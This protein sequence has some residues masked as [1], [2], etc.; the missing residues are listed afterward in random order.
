MQINIISVG[1]LNTNFQAIASDYLKMTKWQIKNTEIN[2]SKKLPSNQIKQF[3]A[4]LI[5][6]NL[7]SNSYKIVLDVL[8]KHIASQEFAGI[9][10]KQMMN[11]KNIDFIIGGAYGLDESVLKIADLK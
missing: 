7:G 4:D 9:F 1:K 10:E 5:S 2:Y 3:E 6:K 8:G 11:G